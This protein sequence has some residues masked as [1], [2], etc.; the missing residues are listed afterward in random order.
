MP[1]PYGW[2]FSQ[3]SFVPLFLCSFFSCVVPFF[4][5]SFFLCCPFLPLF[6]CSFVPV[7]SLCCF[8]PMLSLCSFVPVLSLCSFVPVLSLCFFVPVLSLCSFVPVLSLCT[9]VPLSLCPKKVAWLFF[10]PERLGEKGGRGV[11]Q[12]LTLADKGGR[13]FWL[14]MIS[15]TKIF[16]IHLNIFIILVKFCVFF[17]QNCHCHWI[18][19]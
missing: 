3:N 6:L 7:S 19:W 14:L 5:F 1:D 8:V 9:F 17:L 15:L 4:L 11:R 18:Y 12:M 2:F 16:S 13:G 10:C